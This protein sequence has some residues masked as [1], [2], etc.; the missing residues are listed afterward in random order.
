MQWFANLAIGRKLAIG[1][2][3]LA[4]LL[5]VVGVEGMRTAS[6]IDGL[7]TELNETHAVPA[8]H[9][10][11][12]N[13]QL[14]RISRAVRN[15]ILDDSATAVNKR[16][17]D[18]VKYDSTFRAE[19]KQYQEHVV[20]P[21]MKVMA[22]NLMVAFTNLRPQQDEV[23]ELAR[24]GNDSSAKT[25]LGVIGAQADTMDALMDTLGAAKLA[26]MRSAVEASGKSYRSSMVVLIAL[27]IV[28]LALATVAAIG[29]TRPIVRAVSQLGAVA[30]AL[31]V[32]D[33][34][35]TIHVTSTDE[36]G[37]LARSM[38]RMVDAQK[39]LAAAA[40]AVTAGDMSVEVHSRG[41]QDALGNAFVQ[42]RA[43]MQE[44]VAETSTLVSAA[45][46]GQLSTRGNAKRFSGAYSDLVQGI[47]D[48]LDAV[49]SPI[50]EASEVLARVADRD[51][52]ARVVGSYSGDF[53]KIKDSINTAA[54]TL[55]EAMAQVNVAAEQVAAAGQEIASGSQALAQGSSEQAAS[56]EEVSSSL[57]EMTSSTAQTA[58]N[59]RQARD[60][61]QTARERV[62]QGRASMGQLSTAIDQIK[63]SSDKT[64]K[65]IK[66]IDEIAFQTN[67]LALNAAVEAARAGDAGRGFAVVA[68]EVRNLAIRSAEAARSTATL[69][70]DSVQHAAA[71]VALNAEVL[72]RLGEIDN[73]V[74]RVS[75]VV[76]EI[77]VAGEQQND[78]VRQISTAVT[79]LNGVTQQVAAN[80]EESASASEELAGQSLTLTSMVQSFQISG[81]AKPT[82]DRPSNARRR[83]TRP[84]APEPAFASR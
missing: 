39:S 60:M 63:E 64:A 83:G 47:N 69:I 7:V 29:I 11:E 3:L 58:A 23:V 37:Q 28:A 75:E 1:F 22:A 79:Q 62:T 31:A 38:Q 10:K 41:E 77:A 46:A 44:L 48:T 49:V 4:L 21:D 55:D 45:K 51:L 35:Q 30:E 6:K 42:L 50:N 8:L 70:E 43:T 66:T 53:A 56:L 16:A 59:A 67:L 20:R 9:L 2:G 13:L 82:S 26:L 54:E 76:A 27:L 73:D 84:R 78:G 81:A 18:I 24:A 17:A 15:A 74:R 14:I 12:A 57:H 5:S 19:F 65:I 34:Q 71:G 61:A 52:T 68:E 80:A 72:G 33:V 32:G 40:T 25:R 36:M